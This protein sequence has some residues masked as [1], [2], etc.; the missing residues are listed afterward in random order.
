MST[1]QKTLNLTQMLWAVNATAAGQCDYKV[2][3]VTNATEPKCG[4]RITKEQVDRY[5]DKPDWTVNIT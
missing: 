3:K 5:C 2:V 4:D 1:K